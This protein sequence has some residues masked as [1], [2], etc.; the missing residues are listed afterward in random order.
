MWI[1]IAGLCDWWG[2]YLYIVGIF[3]SS[4]QRKNGVCVFFTLYFIIF[5]NDL[6]MFR[7]SP[8]SK[9]HSL[10]TDWNELLLLFR[11]GLVFSLFLIFLHGVF[12]WNPYS[13]PRVWNIIC[14]EAHAVVLNR[15]PLKICTRLIWSRGN[16]PS[17]LNCPGS[18]AYMARISRPCKLMEPVMSLVIKDSVV[19]VPTSV[20][21]NH[22][23][24]NGLV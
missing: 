14:G 22:Y 5:F 18:P 15:V 4:F 12:P 23:Q 21:N 2:I 11:V 19:H 7:C 16:L 13:T 1:N 6:V 24:Q 3:F 10:I 17:F 20:L 9:L 8:P